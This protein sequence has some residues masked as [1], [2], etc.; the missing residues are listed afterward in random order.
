MWTMRRRLVTFAFA[1][2]VLVVA[3]LLRGA[4]AFAGKYV[5]PPIAGHVTDAAGKL[6]P[7]EIAA[8]NDKLATY[9]KCSSNHIAV[10]FPRSLEGYSVE[11]V[12][13]DTFNTW[14]IGESKKDSGVLLVLAPNERKIRIETGKGVGGDLT[15]VESSHIL[16]DVV[17]PNMKAG[18][19]FQAADQATTRIGAA[20]GR[21]PIADIGSVAGAVTT[22]TVPTSPPSS[23]ASPP[24]A[25]PSSPFDTIMNILSLFVAILFVGGF[26]LIAILSA[27]RRSG[28]SAGGW[29]S[30]ASSS[31]DWSSSSSSSWSS[32]DSSSSSSSDYSGGGGSSGGGGA[33][34]SY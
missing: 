28:T 13:Y 3:L 29:S 17:G 2:A 8:L 34:D 10:F 6:T 23:P 21:C 11:D 12:A 26:I 31:S 27:R 1:F 15:D 4:P 16:R 9:R 22:T 33:S 14:H 7:G 20:L 18:R 19:F 5:P 30:G 32:S 25:R 24:P